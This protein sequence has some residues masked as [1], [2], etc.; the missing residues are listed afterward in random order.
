MTRPLAGIWYNIDIFTPLIFSTR[1]IINFLYQEHIYLQCLIILYF[2]SQNDTTK[3]IIL[4]KNIFF[5]FYKRKN[6]CVK[7]TEQLKR[8]TIT[9]K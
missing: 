5:Y 1:L 3:K 7:K 8:I 2:S 4:I 9:Q 6:I